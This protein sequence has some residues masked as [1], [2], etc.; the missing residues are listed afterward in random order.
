MFLR[1]QLT[2]R[3]AICRTGVKPVPELILNNIHV[4]NSGTRLQW[5][6]HT[7]FIIFTFILISIMNSTAL[8]SMQVTIAHQFLLQ[9]L[10]TNKYN[11]LRVWTAN[12]FWYLNPCYPDHYVYIILNI[13]H[14][15]FYLLYLFLHFVMQ[16]LIM[17]QKG[18]YS[19]GKRH[20]L[21]C[22]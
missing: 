1:V 6:E 10:K 13:R 7:P 11:T 21:V 22:Q 15:Y 16:I 18:M 19:T 17:T 9:F 20:C 5:I 3:M 14:I 12:L 4:M 2:I 8:V